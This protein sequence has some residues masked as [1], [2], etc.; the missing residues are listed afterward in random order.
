MLKNTEI[1]IGNFIR[2]FNRDYEVLAITKTAVLIKANNRERYINLEECDGILLENKWRFWTGFEEER[3]TLTLDDSN[4]L[5]FE[6]THN[7]IWLIA[8]SSHKEKVKRIEFV[9][10][11]QNLYIELTGVEL[12][13]SKYNLD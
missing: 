2:Y 11:A 4:E 6:R 8:A 3:K 12:F 13:I 10:Q 5:F 7:E 1:R 9:H